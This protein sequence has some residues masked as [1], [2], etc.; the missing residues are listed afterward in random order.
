MKQMN[1]VI[2]I[3][4][5]AAS[6]KTTVASLLARRL[7]FLYV[8]TGA[9][10]RALTLK[11]LRAGIQ[12]TDF[13]EIKHLLE[14]T[15]ISLRRRP[16][17][18]TFVALDGEDVSEQINSQEVARAA[19][20][21]SQLRAVRD[22]MVARQREIA[23]RGKAVAEGRDTTTVVFPNAGYKFYLD[24]SLDTR[25]ARRHK[26]LL[27]EGTAIPLEEVKEDLRRRDIADRNRE[28]S[29]LRI[30]PDAVVIDSTDLAPEQVVQQIEKHLA[31]LLRLKEDPP[32]PETR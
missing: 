18:S 15:D 23:G 25:A 3:D 5:P 26:E 21:I 2:A 10:Y 32:P 12:P 8:N 7:G 24:A 13:G 29:P 31:P 28:L 14:V 19:S 22:Y 20:V 11:A 9:M 6:G 1:D 4:G 30:A 27:A 17:A 16:D